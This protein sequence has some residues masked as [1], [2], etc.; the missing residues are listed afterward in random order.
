[1]QSTQ[2]G[3]TKF[4]RLRSSDNHI[5]VIPIEAACQSR[6]IADMLQ[7][8]EAMQRAVNGDE[9]PSGGDSGDVLSL[10]GGTT[11]DDMQEIPLHDI[12]SPVLQLVCH[13][14]VE[15]ESGKNTMS[16]FRALGSMDPTNEKDKQLVLELLLAADYL[17]C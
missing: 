16:E 4:V 14:L 1:M 10:G 9:G 3:K 2:V 7:S 8:I 12:S 11:W 15:K 5:F 6:M 17:D 13:Y